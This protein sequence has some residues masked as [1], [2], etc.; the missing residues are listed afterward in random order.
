MDFMDSQSLAGGDEMCKSGMMFGLVG[1]IPGVLE[2]R[3]ASPVVAIR[4]LENFQFAYSYYLLYTVYCM[5]VETEE[6]SRSTCNASTKKD[7]VRR[8][9]L[10]VKEGTACVTPHRTLYLLIRTPLWTPMT[11][12]G[13]LMESRFLD[14]YITFT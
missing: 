11:N 1:A 9:T 10:Y 5:H 13:T 8:E 7:L 12:L 14:A 4:D 6:I 2:R 3:G